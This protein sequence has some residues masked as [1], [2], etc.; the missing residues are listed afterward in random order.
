[1]DPAKF[2]TIV[3]NLV[4]NGIKHSPAGGRVRIRL[5]REEAQLVLMVGDQGEGIHPED[6]SLLFDRFWR[7]DAVTAGGHQGQGLGLAVVKA[8]VDLLGGTIEVA[9][10]PGQGAEFTCSLPEWE[11][12]GPGAI[13]TQDG[14][15]SFFGDPKEV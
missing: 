15:V 14:N 13:L 4:S 3:A 5:R 12:A 10:R 1:M 7:L 9:C 6:Q 2:Q 8:L 11:S